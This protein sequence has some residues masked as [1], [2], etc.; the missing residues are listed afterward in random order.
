MKPSFTGVSV[1][2]CTENLVGE[3]DLLVALVAVENLAAWVICGP[4]IGLIIVSLNLFCL[5]VSLLK[6]DPPSML[7]EVEDCPI[8]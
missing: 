6:A 3:A 2:P 4:I 1:S 7:R 5:G 8:L